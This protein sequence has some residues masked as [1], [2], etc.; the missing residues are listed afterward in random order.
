MAGNISLKRSAPAMKRRRL[1]GRRRPGMRR[2][3]GDSLAGARGRL[4][5]F[6]Q[7]TLLALV[8]TSLLLLLI[9]PWETGLVDGAEPA[10]FS[11]TLSPDEPPAVIQEEAPVEAPADG[12]MQE[13]EPL[14]QAAAEEA[15]RT[16]ESLWQ[17]FY[18]NLPKFF[19]VLGVV[20]IAWLLVRLIRPL[21]RRTLGRWERA[22]ALIA[23]FG[24]AIWLLAAGISLSVLAGDIR[25][26]VGSLGL[27]GLALSWALQTPIESFTGWLLNSFQGY[28]RVGDRVAVGEVFGDVYQIDFLTTTVWEIGSPGTGGFVQAEQPTGRLIT[29]PNNEV[30]AGTVVNLTRDFPYVWDELTIP[31]ANES[32]LGYGMRVLSGI[33]RELLGTHMAEPARQYDEILRAAGLE[34]GMAEDPQVFIAMNESWTD[35]IIRYLVNARQRRKWKS[36]L[37]LRVMEELKKPEH[38]GR[39]ISVYPRQQLQFL[40]PDGLPAELVGDRGESA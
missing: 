11:A 14:G 20:A 30:L 28:Y 10:S 38:A 19:V 24:I 21:L 16:I 2:R 18:G 26:L 34:M 31:L 6:R 40:G 17:G 13:P 37:T 7:A 35:L 15:A 33:A 39:L 25:A 12:T 36:E 8:I 22:N 3:P 32:D 5:H 27:I 9:A 4:R 23:L 29:F 1:R